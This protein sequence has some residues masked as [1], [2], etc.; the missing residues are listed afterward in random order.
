MENEPV[1]MPPHHLLRLLKAFT[2]GRQ[3]GDDLVVVLQEREVYLRHDQVFIVSGISDEGSF[4][5]SRLGVGGIGAR[6]V[7]FSRAVLTDHKAL[8]A[9]VVQKRAIVGAAAVQVVEIEPRRAEIFERI[10][11]VLTLKL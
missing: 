10:G 9:A 5:G 1:V 2:P 4:P 3:S 7:V 11:I 6:Q 8:A